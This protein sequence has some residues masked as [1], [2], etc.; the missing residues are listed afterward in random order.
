[1]D[2][3]T[4]KI[5]VELQLADIDGLLN[6]LYDEADILHGDT[7]TSFQIVRQ[8]LQQQLQILNDQILLLKIL[9]E[10]STTAWIYRIELHGGPYRRAN[11]SLQ[12]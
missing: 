12:T 9:R 8:D 10:E 11:T 6:G 4:A 7:R 2:P 1:M 5:I 3:K